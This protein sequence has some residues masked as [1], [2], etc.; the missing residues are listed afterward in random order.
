MLVAAVALSADVLA[1]WWGSRSPEAEAERVAELAGVAADD[2]IAEIGAGR[3][4]M[5]RVLAPK[6]LPGGRVFVTELSDTRLTDLRALVD[7]ERW[8]HVSVLQGEPNGTALPDACCNVIYMR[9]V[10]H[11]FADRRQMAAAL[12]RALAPAGR[13]VVIDFEPIWLLSIVEPVEGT[14]TRAHGVTADE[15]ITDLTAVGLTLIRHES[16]WTT[17]SFMTM[18]GHARLEAQQ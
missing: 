2:T 14:S 10:Y 5:L 15:V 6:T 8:R 12:R 16:R 9:H 1:L 18:F 17:G 4:E 7:A 13:L 3:G 11:H